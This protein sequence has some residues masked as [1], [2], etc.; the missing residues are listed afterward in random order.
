VS[1]YREKKNH[2][3]RIRQIVRGIST[4][5]YLGPVT[6]RDRHVGKPYK[7]SQILKDISTCYFRFLNLGF[8]IFKGFWILNRFESLKSKKSVFP[9]RYGPLVPVTDHDRNSTSSSFDTVT[10]RDQYG[11]R[12]PLR[13]RAVPSCFTF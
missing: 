6:N 8:R 11:E 2:P 1:K 9:L 5:G 13:F 12:L 3:S 4:C 10:D 7:S